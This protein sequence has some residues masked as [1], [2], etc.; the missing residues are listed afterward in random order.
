M[1]KLIDGLAPYIFGISGFSLTNQEIDFLGKVKPYGI[2][3]F[4]RNLESKDQIKGLT[5]HIHSLVKNIKIF[6]DQEG[7]R[8]QRIKPP[9]GSIKYKPQKYFGDLYKLDPDRAIQELRENYKDLSLELKELGIDVTCAPVCD[10]FYEN[11]NNGSIMGDRTF[12]SD[13]EIVIILAQE[14]L[15]AMKENGIEGIIKHIPGHGRAL[16]SHKELPFVNASL[17]E[18]EANDCKV[19][20]NLAK[21]E[22]LKYAMTAHIVYKAIDQDNACTVSAKVITYIKEIIGF[23][24]LLI[25]DAI[26]MR[27]LNGSLIERMDRSFKSGCDIVLHC[28]GKIEEMMSLVAESR[29]VI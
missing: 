7:G 19:F 6:I 12:S 1:I 18:L 24:G 22:Y 15:K 11:A 23:K 25:T 9:I 27:A 13:P 29:N 4:P 16:D 20:H 17:K 26:E 2:I 10:L 3:L 28:T 5:N 14:A 8:V 21:L